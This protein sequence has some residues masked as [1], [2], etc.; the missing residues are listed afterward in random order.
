MRAPASSEQAAVFRAACSRLGINQHTCTERLGIRK[1][2]FYDYGNGTLNVPET[3]SKLLD[4]MESYESLMKS[5]VEL[6][7]ELDSMKGCGT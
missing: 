4:S 1:S 2:V 6:Q 3:V 5:F 7:S